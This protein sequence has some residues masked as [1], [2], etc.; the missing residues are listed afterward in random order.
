VTDCDCDFEVGEQVSFPGGQ[1]EITK[2]NHRD[3]GSCL[4][5]IHTGDGLTKRPTALQIEKV[6]TG[7]DLLGKGSFDCP[8]HFDLRFRAVRL[9][10]AHREDRFVALGGSR[11]DIEPYQVQAA[12]EIL[13]SYDHRYLIGDEVGLGKTIEAAIVIEELIARDRADRVLIVTPAPLTTQWQD[14]MREKFDRDYMVYERDYVDATREGKPNENVWMQDD[15]IITSIDFA[16]QDDMLAALENL[17]EEWD[18]A[19]FDESHHLTAR[20]RSDDTVDKTER[21]RVGE[22][23]ADNSDGLIFL[24]GTPHKGKPDQFYFM[25]SLLDPYRFRSEH[26]ITPDALD[27]LMIQ[28]LKEDMYNADGTKMFPDKNIETLGVNFTP[29]ERRLYDNVTEYIR[30]H[31]NLATQADNNVAGFAMAIYQKRLV[32]SIH[33]IRRSLK[34]RMEIIQAGGKDPDDLSQEVQA[35]L[36]KYRSD[37][38]LLTDY[39][40]EKVEEE[41]G[42]V[43][44]SRGA[45]HAQQELE[46]VQEL[47]RQS[48]AID[49]DSKAQR[50]R[51]FVD[52]VLSEDPEEKVLVFTEYTDT[53]EYLRERVFA[54]M[55]VAQIYGDLGQRRR[56]Q[57]IE[58]FRDEANV[59]LATDAAREG[60]N[61]QFAHIMV[62]YDLPWNPTRIDQ[63]IGRLHRY[64]QENTV[65]IRNLFVNNTRESEILELLVEKINEIESTLGMNS[66]VLGL[67]LDE[68]NLE[69]QI[70]TAIAR[71]EDPDEVAVEV[72][73]L[74]EEQ[75]E[76]LQRIEQDFLIRD[77]FDLS[78][79]DQEILEVLE[80]SR[81]EGVSEQD[82]ENLVRGFFDEF[83]GDIRGIR[84][85]P[86]RDAGDVFQLDVPDSIAGGNVDEQYPRATFTREV[87]VEN[88]EVAFIALDHPLV[89]NIIEFC[90]STDHVR[91]QTAVKVGADAMKTPGLL[92]NYRL[93]YLSGR[94]ETVT[95]RIEEIYVTPDKEVTTD[96]IDI[97]GALP[98]DRLEEYDGIEAISIIADQLVES[99]EDRA[100][101]LVN[102]MAEEAREERSREVSI[103][104]EHADRYFE[105]RIEELET[106][107]A[108]Y[109]DRQEREDADMSAA[110]NRV[111]GELRELREERDKEFQRLDEESQVVP[112]EPEFINA[113][114]V[115]GL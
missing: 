35:L 79:E 19:I 64:G 95:E 53:L 8:A 26:D 88:D 6:D 2:I 17:D 20:R 33:A 97:V 82:V 59:M 47:H 27:D 57:E 11:I 31:Y 65:E 109:R 105:S 37:P 32:S 85:G 91:G 18:I 13:S 45:D 102:Q 44:V 29:E 22:A 23:V 5:Y 4:L 10:L 63:R 39:Q 90:Q 60:I 67:V 111:R 94:G 73:S 75:K 104:R 16:K 71:D 14:E 55:D 62:N 69:D 110:I 9:D 78:N 100:W 1:G 46:I 108:D 103:K 66:D 24:T 42:G 49:T 86:A 58:K 114:V 81:E 80:R 48:K 34:N 115:I 52:G 72:D 30:N 74:I 68:F 61:L 25:I 84:P 12:Y 7:I 101:E 70:M 41:I 92:C 89:R 50:L 56:R 40:R 93:R 107:L 106:T 113:A 77:R 38:D 96:G 15:R 51:E 87:A 83:G 28:R 99:A 54:D 21:Y 98:P 43:T 3:G 76:A 36:S 112:D